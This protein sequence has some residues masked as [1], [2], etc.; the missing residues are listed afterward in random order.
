MEP[1]GPN[2]IRQGSVASA[3]LTN[4]SKYITIIDDNKR[5][6]NHNSQTNNNDDHQI[7]LKGTRKMHQSSLNLG[8]ST[9]TKFK[10]TSQDVC[11]HLFIE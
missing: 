10:S 6:Y 8:N 3:V 1:T 9:M 2:S 5:F 11:M 7:S 4:S